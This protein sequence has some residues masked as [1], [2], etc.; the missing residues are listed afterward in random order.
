M[1][2]TYDIYMKCIS[3]SKKSGEYTKPKTR[4]DGGGKGRHHGGKGN[5][6]RKKN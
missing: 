5:K 4:N 3:K 1:Q 2:L 6:G